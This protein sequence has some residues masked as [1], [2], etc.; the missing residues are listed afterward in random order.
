MKTK[1]IVWIKQ[2]RQHT[3]SNPGIRKQLLEEAYEV[4]SDSEKRQEYN[5]Q[6]F[7]TNYSESNDEEVKTESS[8]TTDV[9]VKEEVTQ[10]NKIVTPSVSLPFL[11]IDENLLVGALL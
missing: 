11:D 2:T 4:L 7:V 8:Q 9:L 5:H 6:F 10:E 1:N 3:S